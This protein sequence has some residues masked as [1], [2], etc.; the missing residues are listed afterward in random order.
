[1]FTGETSL[2][3]PSAMPQSSNRLLSSILMIYNLASTTMLP[4]LKIKIKRLYSLIDCVFGGFSK[5]NIVP[6]FFQIS[7]LL[8]LDLLQY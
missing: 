8:R 7:D 6:V 2:S 3:K 5:I 1:M 4:G